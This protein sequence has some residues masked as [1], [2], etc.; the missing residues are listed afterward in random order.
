MSNRLAGVV[1]EE[2]RTITVN[3]NKSDQQKDILKGGG[4]KEREKEEGKGKEEKPATGGDGSHNLARTEIV[5]HHISPSWI[6]LSLGA[7]A[8]P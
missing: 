1:G 8:W 4:G 6:V 2:R 5:T 7:P 3:K